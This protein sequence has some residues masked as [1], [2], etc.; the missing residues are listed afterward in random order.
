MTS[1]LRTLLT[2]PVLAQSLRQSARTLAET[3]YDWRVL[4]DKLAAVYSLI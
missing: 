2:N 4:S 1:A 3:Q